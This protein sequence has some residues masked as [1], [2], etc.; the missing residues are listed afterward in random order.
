MRLASSRTR[1]QLSRMTICLALIAKARER[2]VE[3][4]SRF[5]AGPSGSS[6]SRD[7]TGDVLVVPRAG[8]IDEPDAVLDSLS[9]TRI[10]SSASRLF[11][12]PGGP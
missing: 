9:S 11:P 8:E 6:T 4:I 3:R 1:A 2:M 7:D 12:T 5:H 10:A